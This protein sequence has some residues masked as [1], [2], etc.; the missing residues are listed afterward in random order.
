MLP[1]RGKEPFGVIGHRPSAQDRRDPLPPPLGEGWGEGM[2][3]STFEAIAAPAPIPTFPQRG[4]G[5]FGDIGHRRMTCRSPKQRPA[6]A[7]FQRGAV[8]CSSRS[9]NC[10]ACVRVSP[11]ISALG[12]SERHTAGRS[13]R[14]NRRHRRASSRCGQGMPAGLPCGSPGMALLMEG[15]VQQAAQPGRQSIGP[16][17]LFETA[18]SPTAPARPPPWPG[19]VTPP[20]TAGRPGRKP[21]G[22]WTRRTAGVPP[23]TAN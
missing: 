13:G 20:E 2:P 23:S 17:R 8:A 10:I 15:A 6:H 18:A 4:K 11:H 7:D 9:R 5:P 22:P 16:V 3:A 21:H 12:D 14:P 19:C 1:Q